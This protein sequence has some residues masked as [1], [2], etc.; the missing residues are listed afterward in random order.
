VTSEGHRHGHLDRAGYGYAH[1][2]SSIRSAS[3]GA[4]AGGDIGT[5]I[6]MGMGS[7][8]LRT[9]PQPLVFPH[10]HGAGA[11]HVHMSAGPSNTSSS[12]IDGRVGAPIAGS[13]PSAFLG[14]GAISLGGQ[15][16]I[17]FGG[18]G[19]E[20]GGGTGGGSAMAGFSSASSAASSVDGG[21]H[22]W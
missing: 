5:R 18:S 20:V 6:P 21:V 14:A 10:E 9:P 1:G 13:G 3:V 7:V 2:I 16:G 17:S 12:S 8:G 19:L 15:S 4:F 11:S 22:N